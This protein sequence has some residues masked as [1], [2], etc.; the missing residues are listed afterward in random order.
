MVLPR[1]LQNISAFENIQLSCA[2]LN[3]NQNIFDNMIAWLLTTNSAGTKK[4]YD[5]R[6]GHE[7]TFYPTIE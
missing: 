1:G 7:H 2:C 5:A 4:S 6:D 3:Q